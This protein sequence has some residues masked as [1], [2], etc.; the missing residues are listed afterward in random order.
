MDNTHTQR[1]EYE[2]YEAAAA[3]AGYAVVIEEL[4]CESAA[5]ARRLGRRNT[6]GVPEAAVARMF[7][8]WERARPGGA[9]VRVVEET[10]ILAGDAATPETLLDGGSH[11]GGGGGG[12]SRVAAPH[13]EAAADADGWVTQLPRG[14]RR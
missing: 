2:K 14:K 5:A 10:K 3:E 7:D 8:R 11:A 12:R 13:G 6:H 1:W 9:P 4:R